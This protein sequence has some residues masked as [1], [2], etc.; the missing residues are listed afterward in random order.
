MGTNLE[1]SMDGRLD[2]RA[3]ESRREDL[4][5]GKFGM[6]SGDLCTEGSDR[7]AKETEEDGERKES[8]DGEEMAGWD[9]D[10]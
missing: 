4:R 9:K 8:K 5:L 6:M 3:S 1:G 7:L 2:E 10:Q